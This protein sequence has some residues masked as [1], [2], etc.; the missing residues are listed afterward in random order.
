MGGGDVGGLLICSIAIY[1]THGHTKSTVLTRIFRAD[2]I[3]AL[4]TTSGS[5][6]FCTSTRWTL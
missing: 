4:F 1:L 6:A 3:L 2:H 5:S